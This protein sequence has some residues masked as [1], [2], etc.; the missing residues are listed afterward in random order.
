MKKT[1]SREN[2]DADITSTQQKLPH[3]PWISDRLFYGWVIVF[4]GAI[5]QFFQ[6]ITSQGSAAYLEPL[7]KQFGWSNAVM[8]GPRSINMINNSILGPVEGYL[9]DRFGPRRIAAAGI[10]V[11]GGG[12][13][14]F[15]FTQNLWMYYLSSIIIAIGTG[16]QGLLVMSVAVNNWFRRKRSLSQSIMLLGFPLAGV[17]AVP[18]IVLVQQWMGWEVSA[19]GSGILIWV[20]GFPCSMLLRSTPEPYGLLP[21]GDA[22]PDIASSVVGEISSDAEYNFTLRQAIRTR[23]FWFL[24]ASWAIGNLGMGS[25]QFYILLHL[26]SG[27]GLE[28]IVASLVWT[29]ASTS[30]IPARLLGGVFGDRLPK[31]LVIGVSM[32]LMAGAI[33]V[34]AVAESLPMAMVYAV[35]YGIGWGVRTPVMNAI[36]GE[37]FGRTS[38]GIIRGWLQSLGL[39]LVIAAPVVVGYMADVQGTFRYAFIILAFITLAS[40]ALMFLATHPKRPDAIR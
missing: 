10:F 15:G 35:L 27:V 30:N 40:A 22:S 17:V 25:V 38:Q 3:I 26:T 8:A 16:F 12:L 13:I 37:Y 28:R 7:S 2:G 32:I 29:V 34:L 4:V 36:Q 23:S 9:V 33:Y 31:N 18:A 11:M 20:V 24:A 39:P 19:I 6:G 5:T 21:D 1:D 14:L